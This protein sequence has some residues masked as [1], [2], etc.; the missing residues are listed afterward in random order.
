MRPY[1]Q[2][3]SRHSRADNVLLA[4]NCNAP[5]EYMEQFPGV[6]ALS[7][8]AEALAGTPAETE[9][10]QHG[11]FLPYLS[12]YEDDLYLFTD[13]DIVLQRP[14]GADEIEW[15][16][17]ATTGGRVSAGWNSGP[18]ETLAIEARRLFPRANVREL[19]GPLVDAPCFNIGVFALRRQT[20]WHI[21]N[22]YMELWPRAC[23]TFGGPARQQWLVCYVL[24]ELGI[25][26]EPMPYTLHTHGCYARP[27][28]SR[29]EGGLLMHGQEVVAFRHHV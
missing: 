22:R 23:E 4:V 8:P 29:F 14:L 19:W 13:G 15:L 24:A 20:Y 28:E 7:L 18:T 3:L 5:P 11:G 12:G 17:R 25:R 6:R 10:V 1:L 16:E 9:S 2:S 21:Y 26:V 27:P